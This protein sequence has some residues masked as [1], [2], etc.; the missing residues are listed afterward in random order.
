MLHGEASRSFC[1]EADLQGASID[2]TVIKVYACAAGVANR[3]SGNEALGNSKGGIGCKVH[4]LCD[5]LGMPIRF[6][7]AGGQESG[8]KQAIPLLTYVETSAV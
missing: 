1:E 8:G 6:I 2:G 5:A 4:V 7:L 3:S